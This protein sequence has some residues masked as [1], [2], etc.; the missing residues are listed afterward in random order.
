MKV[1]LCISGQ[2]RFYKQGFLEIK[3]TF[4]DRYDCDVFLHT[5]HSDSL[6]GKGYDSTHSGA[7]NLIGVV[8]EDT[9]NS[10]VTLYK[11]VSFLIDEPKNFHHNI[12]FTPENIKAGVQ[13]N[14]IFSMFYSI[15]KSI[16]I[17]K[18]Y[19]VLNNFE[20][21]LTVRLRFDSAF[22]DYIELEK[23][24]PEQLYV[25]R[26]GNPAVYYDIFGF[27][28]STLMNYYGNTFNNIEKVW[29]PDKHFIGENIL[30][31]SL[32]LDE[33]PVLKLDYQVDLIRGV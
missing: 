23:H 24:S 32:V 17:K 28:T 19:E 10:L 5:W 4:I 31:D 12:T 18:E 15:K 21:D 33:V 30:T 3:K 16:D 26:S 1:S 29:N 9:P 27:G 8:E 25:L 7:G 2:P 6:I 13:P 20:Y 22:S 11:P 14:N